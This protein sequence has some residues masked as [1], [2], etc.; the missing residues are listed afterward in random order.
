MLK[1]SSKNLSIRT[2]STSLPITVTMATKQPHYASSKKT[3]KLGYPPCYSWSRSVK[4]LSMI[5]VSGI[6]HS[7]L[8]LTI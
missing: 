1:M 4:V 2:G 8:F 7:I 6:H 3:K 5:H